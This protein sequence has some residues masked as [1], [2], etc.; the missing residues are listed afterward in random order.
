[1]I[2]PLQRSKQKLQQIEEEVRR[3]QEQ[4]FREECTFRPAINPNSSILAQH[5]LRRKDS[6]GELNRSFR[7]DPLVSTM[8]E[9][10][11]APKT[12]PVKPDMVTAQMY[13]EQNP[14]ERLYARTIAPQ[15]STESLGG[16]APRSSS[17]PPSPRQLQRSSSAG[18]L[19][20]DDSGHSIHSA[21]SA[22]SARSAHSGHSGRSGGRNGQGPHTL[23]YS[24][25]SLQ[26]SRSQ[27]DLEVGSRSRSNAAFSNFLNRM[28]E[29]EAIRQRNLDRIK[30]EQ[31]VEQGYPKLNRQSLA[32]AERTQ[33]AF[34]E[35]LAFQVE[36][37]QKRH[38]LQEYLDGDPECTFNPAI[39]L[40]SKVRPPRS[41]DELSKGDHIKRETKIK[42]LMMAEE[43]RELNGAT[44]QPKVYSTQAESILKVKSDPDHYMLRVK[45]HAR[46]VEERNQRQREE[47]EQQRLAECTFNP[48]VR[49][50]PAFVKR[51]AHSIKLT[52]QMNPPSTSSQPDWR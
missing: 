26:H 14:F 33:P 5:A 10:T 12:N 50:S 6:E 8:A 47:F 13:L 38:Q 40:R 35:R 17:S 3:Q 52:R 18:S 41:Y 43:E 23:R 49:D 29:R 31:E 27:D 37:I 21:H 19:V 30:Q 48:Q 15:A 44:F 24:L 45:N 4:K 32:I 36:K 11:F 9:C 20:S 25:S 22:Q 34:M 16:R 39:N 28:H 46:M 51:I 2:L 42:I 1:M 7:E